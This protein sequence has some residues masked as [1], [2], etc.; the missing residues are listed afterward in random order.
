MAII[1]DPNTGLF[2]DNSTGKVYKDA[3]GLTPS[4]N[5]GLTQQAQRNLQIANELF[6]RLGGDQNRYREI[7]QRQSEL[8]RRLDQQ[9]NGTAPSVAQTQLEEG[10]ETVRQQAD[11]QASGASG[12]AAPL[13][14]YAAIQATG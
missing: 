12:A 3:N 13:A 10:A 6:A 11:S 9:I 7:F 2:V 1:A 14:R 4:D 5:P 8:G